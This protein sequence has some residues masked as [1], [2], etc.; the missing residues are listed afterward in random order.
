MPSDFQAG[1]ALNRHE[2]SEL[3][4]SEL[5]DAVDRV[6]AVDP[7]LHRMLIAAGTVVAN[8][9]VGYREWAMLTMATLIAIGDAQDQLSIYLR[10]AVRNGATDD[11]ILDVVNQAALYVGAPRAVNAARTIT[12]YLAEQRQRRL[13]SVTES[14]VNVGDHDTLVWDNGGSGVPMLLVHALSL[15]HRI[16]REV[17]PQLAAGGRVIAYDLRGHGYARGAPLTESLDHLADD[18]RILMDRLGLEQADVYGASFGGAIAQHVALNF[19]GRVRSLALIATASIA[20]GPLLARAEAAEQHGMEAQ[21][22]ETLIR[23]FS[24]RTIAENGW[25]VRYARECVRRN[26]VQEWAAAWRAMAELDV[27]DRLAEI[28]V[29]SVAIAGAQDVSATPQYMRQT[30]D[31]IPGCQYRVLDPGTHMMTMEQPDAL[32]GALREFRREVETASQR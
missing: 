13:P 15:D 17:Y 3:A 20:P 4:G 16:W 22:A 21:I 9:I 8:S 2:L 24:S 12:E 10:A 1:G 6:A 29:P 30:A 32:A 31:G 19:G 25:A 26:R 18:L 23:W 7:Q 5:V 14:T 11:E 27:V 28:D